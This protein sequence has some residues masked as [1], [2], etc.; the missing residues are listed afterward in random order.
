MIRVLFVTREYP[1]FEIGGVA[2]HAFHLVKNLNGLGVSCKVLSFGDPRFSNED[3]TFLEPSSSII[4]RSN[5]PVNMDV[6][7]PIDILRFTRA[8]NK[9]IKNEDFDI[10]H[11]EEPYVGAFVRHE[12][13][14]TMIQDTSYGEI[15]TSLPNL[16]LKRCIFFTSLGP[17]LELMCMASSRIVIAP[18]LQVA[19]ELTGVYRVPRSKIKVIRN[20]VEIPKAIKTIDKVKAKQKLKLSETVLIFTAAR[21][22]ARKRLDTLIE[23]ARLLHE[24]GMSGFRFVIAGDGP[25]RLS[26]TKLVMKYG[27]QQKI[28][29]PGWVSWKELETYYRAADIFVLTSSYETGPMSLLEAM[30]FGDV[31][32]SSRIDYFP[33]LMRN[34]IDGLLFQVGNHRALHKCIRSLLNDSPL[35]RRL[36]T[37]GR[38]FAERFGW[39]T[40]AK[41]TLDIYKDIM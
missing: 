9:I 16:N 5:C 17:Y 19:R 36:S 32:I 27:L 23:A 3:V 39:E 33:K 18:L 15:I 22:V 24:A 1:P 12:R 7:I 29:F 35:R 34:G 10:V 6:K 20:G 14:V 26:L 4:S 21:F 40:V 13:K 31:A 11:I 25:L 30:S 8:A 41:R 38:M 28:T 37:S 2:R